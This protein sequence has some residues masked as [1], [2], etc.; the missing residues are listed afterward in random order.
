MLDGKISLLDLFELPDSNPKEE[1]SSEDCSQ[2][3]SMETSKIMVCTYMCN[4]KTGVME[5]S[6]AANFLFTLLNTYFVIDRKFVT[7]LRLSTV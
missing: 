2:W 7:F 1:N 5:T 6:L 4:A 3:S